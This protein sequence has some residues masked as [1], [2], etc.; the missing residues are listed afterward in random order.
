MLVKWSVRF[1]FKSN[2]KRNNNG[3]GVKRLRKGQLVVTLY[4]DLQELKTKVVFLFFSDSLHSFLSDFL[5][6]SKCY[7]VI[8]HP[9]KFQKELH[10]Q[11]KT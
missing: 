4:T 3:G 6:Y 1:I 2:T 7:G 9:I 10:R 8:D 5:K 11:I